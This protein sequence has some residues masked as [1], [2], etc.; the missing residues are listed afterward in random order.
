MRNRQRDSPG[1]GFLAFE[2][3]I[4]MHS[5]HRRGLAHQPLILNEEDL[6]LTNL[7]Q[8]AILLIKMIYPDEMGDMSCPESDIRRI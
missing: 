8:I 2:E 7:A 5:G 3:G 6:H 1:G 4:F